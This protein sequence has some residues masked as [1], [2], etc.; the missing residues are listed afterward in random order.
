MTV[1][2]TSTKKRVPRSRVL[3]RGLVAFNKRFST[4]ECTVTDFSAAGCK[5]KSDAARLIPDTFELLI[6]LDGLWYPATAVWRRGNDVGVQF[7]GTPEPAKSRRVQSVGP[8]KPSSVRL[9]A[10]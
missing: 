8:T 5:I 4:V 6:E 10:K 1:S 3:K 7:T 9:R 2:D